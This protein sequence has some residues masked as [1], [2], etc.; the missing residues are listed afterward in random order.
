MY[1]LIIWRNRAPIQAPRAALPSR[2]S[3]GL[4]S[5]ILACNKVGEFDPKR[6]FGTPDCVALSDI[7]LGNLKRKFIRDG[8]SA[9]TCNLGAAV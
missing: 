5:D 6:V 7:I 4:I 2:Y 9:D 8:V 3:F 1:R